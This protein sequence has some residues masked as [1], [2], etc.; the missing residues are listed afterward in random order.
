MEG[1][2][3]GLVLAPYGM[4]DPSDHFDVIEAGYPIPDEN[5]FL[6]AEKILDL[7]S[8][9]SED[10]LVVFILSSGATALTILPLGDITYQEMVKLN[11]DMLSCGIPMDEV[12]FVRSYLTFFGG[13]RLAKDIYPTPISVLIS[14]DGPTEQALSTANYLMSPVHLDG[15]AVLKTLSKYKIDC[16]SSIEN[17]LKNQNLKPPN[18]DHPCFSNIQKQIIASWDLL[19]DGMPRAQK[20]Q[21]YEMINLGFIEGDVSEVA[22]NIS[23]LCRS[24]LL[25]PCCHS[26]LL[27]FGG[28]TTVTLTGTGSGGRNMDFLMHLANELDQLPGV[29]AIAA[30]TDGIDGPTTAAGA[31]ISPTTIR[32]ATECGMDIQS[33]INE[34]NGYYFFKQLDDLIVTGATEVD[35]GDFKAIFIEPTSTS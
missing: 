27:V 17:F 24:L 32:R 30:D 5:V 29:F 22:L 33:Y 21:D 11:M 13:G 18:K 8:N 4:G 19:L 10:D 25:E 26:R 6:A 16:P 2:L 23:D 34:N 20:A 1:P 35:L 15:N 31:F 3:E 7:I 9:L 12:R 14:L 28:E